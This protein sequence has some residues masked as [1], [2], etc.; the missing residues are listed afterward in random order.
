MG[1]AQRLGD[2]RHELLGILGREHA[3]LDEALGVALAHRRLGHDALGLERLRVG[4]L[5]LLLMAE[6]PVADDVDHEVVA[7]LLAIGERKAGSGERRLRIVGV[8][9]HDR[10]VEPLREV[11]RV[12]RRAAFHRVGREADLVVRDQVQGA[13]RGVPLQALQ[14]ER[15]GDDALSGERRV[16]VDQDRQGDR[17]VVQP[18]ARP[19]V[20]LLGTRP[21]LHHR[22]DRLEVARVRR[23]RHLDLAAVGHAR[24]GRRK[25]VLHVAAAAFRVDDERV[26]GTLSLELA[27]DGL[28]RAA[29]GVDEGVEP[30]PVSHPDHDLVRAADGGELDRLVEHRHQ[31]IEP[32]E[33]ELLLSEEGPTQVALEALDLRQPAQQPDLFLRRPLS[34]EAAGLDRLAQPDPLG[35]IRDVLDLVRAGAHVDLAQPRERLEQRLARDREPE[36]PRGD[37]RLELRRQRRME[38]ALVE[39]GVAHRL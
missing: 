3:G 35:V 27:Q 29:D 13:A 21:A 20:G 8:D 34:T 6:A 30:A 12:A 16:A 39:C 36:E 31:H 11:A 24:A 5:V 9:M 32:F 7:E 38:A 14:V 33:R 17:R 18:R 19:A 1:S 25:V 4:R 15:L 37:P 26:V 28:V 23:D 2:L 10:H 22:V